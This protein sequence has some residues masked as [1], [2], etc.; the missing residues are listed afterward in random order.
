MHPVLFQ[1]GSF[2][3]RAYGAL[4]VLGFLLGMWRIVTV[5]RHRMETEPEGS[6]R[7]IHPDA[8]MDVGLGMLFAGIL[9]ARLLYVVLDPKSYLAD[10]ISI[11]KIW[12]GGL[13]LHGSLIFGTL[14]LVFYCRKKKIPV[15]AMGDLAATCFPIA[16]AFGRIGCL[17]NGCCYGGVCDLPWGV[18]FPDELHPGQMTLPS[19]PVQ[20]YAFVLHLCFFG[21]LALYERQKRRDGDLFYGYLILY[22]VYRYAMEHFR[23]GVTSTYLVPS[24]HLTDTHIISL[25]MI[26]LGAAGLLW[27]RK[28]RKAYRD[29]VPMPF[30]FQKPASPALAKGG[31]S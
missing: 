21:L 17:L 8:V 3:V 2:P 22:G 14:W 28:N 29:A 15:L 18:R 25:V 16:Y 6:P 5:G 4:V 9:G 27:L 20:L 7:R 12:S 11:L 23:A 30:P 31:Q 24:L 10:P 26:A 13:S 19:H 1:I